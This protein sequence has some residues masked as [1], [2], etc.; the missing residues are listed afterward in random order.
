MARPAIPTTPP[1]PA[2]EAASITLSEVLAGDL[3]IEQKLAVAEALAVLSDVTPPYPP[4]RATSGVTPLIPGVRAALA[5]LREA[6][7]GAHSVEEASRCAMAARALLA[8]DP[9]GTAK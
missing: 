3:D 1:P 7:D 8:L 4:L 2:I 6:I 9:E 5:S